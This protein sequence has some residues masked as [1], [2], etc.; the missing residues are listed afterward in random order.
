MANTTASAVVMTTTITS[1]D[2]ATSQGLLGGQAIAA[3]ACASFIFVFLI[4]AGVIAVVRAVRKNKKNA[5]QSESPE[6]FVDNRRVMAMTD[7]PKLTDGIIVPLSY[8]VNSS[9]DM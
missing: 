1:P 2:S 3:I 6:F 4:L 7:I 8:K 5:V 9:A